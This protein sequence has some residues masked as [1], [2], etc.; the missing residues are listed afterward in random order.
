MTQLLLEIVS[1]T[2]KYEDVQ[3]IYGGDAIGGHKYC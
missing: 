3:F 1:F 2:K